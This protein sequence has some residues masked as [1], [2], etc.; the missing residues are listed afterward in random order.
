[1]E[2][3]EHLLSLFHGEVATAHQRLDEA[4]AHAAQLLDGAVHQR[5]GVAG[6]VALVVTVTAVAHH[7]DHDVLVEP[8]A[9]RERQTCHT[10]AGLGVVAVDVDDRRLHRLGDVGGVLRAASRFRW[11]GEPQLVVHDDVDGSA[12]PVALDEREVERLGDHTLAS[13]RR[14]AVHE[15]RQH[16]ERALV[17]VGDL[18]H[19]GSCH[20]LDHRIDR[21]EV[22]RV[23]RQ[24]DRQRGAGT[25]LEGALRSQVVLHVARALD[26]VGVDIALE[27]P[28]ELRVR[29]ADDVGQHVQTSAVRH[30][31]HGGVEALIGCLLQHCVEDRDERLCALQAEP[32][33]AQVL[34][35]Q[36]LLER[37]GSVEAVEDVAL[38]VDGQL[39][40]RP[41]DLLLDPA[42]LLGLLDV[43]VLD[44]DRTAVR[45]A[46]DVEDLAER[47]APGATDRRVDADVTAGEE[48]AVEIPDRQPVGGRVELGVHLGRLRCERVQVSYEVTADPVH[49][50]EGRHLH[51]LDELRGVVVD[52]VGVLAPLHGLVG[53]PDRPEH[54]VVEGLLAHQQTVDVLQQHP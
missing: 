24:A 16:G 10:H 38:V 7:V 54:L 42:L 50:D 35:G 31:E 47:Q 15:D 28:E 48:L 8:L 49:V 22:R 51:L 34:G 1:M 25:R 30:A 43:H 19:P 13:E 37:L 18:V 3:L 33:L 32:L 39:A 2:V 40:R 46:Q 36:E 52:G 27:L 4:L 26:G 41:L 6:V 14:V 44:A 11:R 17:L 53:H 21:L 45:V 20:A 29:L 23:G 9:V 5:L 12:D